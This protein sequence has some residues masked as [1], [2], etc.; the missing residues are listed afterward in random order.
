LIALPLVLLVVFVAADTVGY[1]LYL[2]LKLLF[3]GYFYIV[4]PEGVV[5]LEAPL[6]E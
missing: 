5:E 2:F 1:L 3:E 6:F 4:V